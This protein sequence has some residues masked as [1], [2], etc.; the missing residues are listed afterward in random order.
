MLANAAWFAPSVAFRAANVPEKF[1]FFGVAAAAFWVA[2]AVPLTR[3]W[4]LHGVLIAMLGFEISMFAY[5]FPRACR[6]MDQSIAELPRDLLRTAMDEC[7]R[8]YQRVQRLAPGP[9]RP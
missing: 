6:L 5:V 7:R 3:V 9:R 1:A 4:Q 2:A 8:A